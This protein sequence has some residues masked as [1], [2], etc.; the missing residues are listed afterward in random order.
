MTPDGLRALSLRTFKA[1]V[2]CAIVGIAVVIA[3][4]NS[5]YRAS[6]DPVV[7]IIG[8]SGLALLGVAAVTNLVSLLSGAVAWIKG[9]RRCPWIFASALVLLVPGGIWVAVMLNL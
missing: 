1:T 4:P 6:T 2:Y 3:I 7:R 9:A 5:T 8:M